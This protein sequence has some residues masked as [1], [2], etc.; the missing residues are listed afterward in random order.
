MWD[1]SDDSDEAVGPDDMQFLPLSLG[2]VEQCPSFPAY[3]KVG[4][5][6]QGPAA[7]TPCCCCSVQCT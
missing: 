3:L 7:Q 5:A 2:A 4:C 6:G 1:A